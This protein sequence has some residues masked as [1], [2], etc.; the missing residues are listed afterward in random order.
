MAA[1]PFIKNKISSVGLGSRVDTQRALTDQNGRFNGLNDICKSLHR[2][3]VSGKLLL[4][5][6]DAAFRTVAD[7]QAFGINEPN[8]L[9]SVFVG[10]AFLLQCHDNQLGD[11]DRCLTQP[12]LFINSL[13]GD[14][15]SHCYL[16]GTLE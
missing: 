9:E 1:A 12:N 2:R 7:Q 10:H 11:A 16:S 5:S 15:V 3:M 4:V 6:S 8:L 13:P 14:K